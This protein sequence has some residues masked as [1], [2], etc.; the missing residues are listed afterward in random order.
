[1]FLRASTIYMVIGKSTKSAD[2][3]RLSKKYKAL[4]K[5]F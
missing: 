4:N 2:F 3:N 5:Y 1:M